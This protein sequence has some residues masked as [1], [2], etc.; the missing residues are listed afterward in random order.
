MTADSEH[1]GPLGSEHRVARLVVGAA[2]VGLALCL[3]LPVVPVLGLDL[4]G[5]VYN[6][7]L[8]WTTDYAQVWFA[9]ADWIAPMRA[10]LWVGLVPITVLGTCALLFRLGEIVRPGLDPL[11]S[12]GTGLRR[13]LG[14]VIFALFALA[15]VPL[16]L[17]LSTQIGLE[18]MGWIEWYA[19]VD[20][21]MEEVHALGHIIIT[22]VLWASG[23]A[24]TAWAVAPRG[25]RWRL[26]L[27]VR[28]L[29]SLPGI[30]ALL[31]LGLG[32]LLLASI[33]GIRAT[34]AAGTGEGR[35]LHA[36]QCG[37]CHER[38]L[39]LYFVKTPGEWASTVDTHRRIEQLPIDEG[40][41]AALE[42][43]LGGMRA[44]DDGW[45]FRTRCQNCHGSSWRRWEDRPT[46]DWAAIASRLA[47][48]SP[49]YYS[50]EVREQLV[51]HVEG[52]K[53]DSAS[54]LGFPAED[55]ER[56]QRIGRECDDCHSIGY[57]AERYREASRDE[58]RAM[59]ARMSQKMADPYNEERIDSATDDW[60]EVI[61]DEGVFARLYPHDDPDDTGGGL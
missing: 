55:W 37:A 25:S 51:R 52:A 47:R 45:T 40:E 7:Y 18:L 22:P 26:P 30:A 20:P 53:G 49:Y 39:P 57:E 3:L 16:G 44:F 59:V 38:S 2:G 27:R 28:R 23:L 29:T 21:T 9:R 12:L 41:A 42:A 46:E 32:A 35:A 17:A 50:D 1:G 31:V 5:M 19:H 11:S 60:L 36:E 13:G 58:T 43:F 24:V 8:D 10:A 4:E 54:T 15:A 14:G 48:W 61:E 56:Y 33:A 6:H 34:R